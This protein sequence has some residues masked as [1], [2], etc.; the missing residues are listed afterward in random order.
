MTQKITG[1]TYSTFAT[2][3]E[4]K[5]ISQVFLL[6][7]KMIPLLLVAT[8]IQRVARLWKRTEQRSSNFQRVHQKFTP[9][10]RLRGLLARACP[11]MR[12]GHTATDHRH[13]GDR[14][15]RT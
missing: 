14:E 3:E 10:A 4:K 7:G 2:L 12:G 6:K 5:D 1:T 13:G 8:N 11:V 15:S 9:H